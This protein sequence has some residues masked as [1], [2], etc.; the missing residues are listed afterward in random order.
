LSSGPARDVLATFGASQ[1]RTEKAAGPAVT[2]ESRMRKNC[3]RW[4]GLAWSC[5]CVENKPTL[6][7]TSRPAGMAGIGLLRAV[8]GAGRQTQPARA[9][10]LGLRSTEAGCKHRVGRDQRQRQVSEDPLRLGRLDG[11]PNLPVPP[12]A[13]PGVN[14]H[15]THDRPP[16]A[17][18]MAGA[19]G[20]RG[21]CPR[22]PQTGQVLW[23]H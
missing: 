7:G 13:Y 6:R 10:R 21:C 16:Q 1:G 4:R 14:A 3:P 15:T 17:G 11:V 5:P 9:C 19:G 12:S 8:P 18:G 22:A 20:P 23:D 2:G